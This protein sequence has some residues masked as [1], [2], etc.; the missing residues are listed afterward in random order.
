MP[1]KLSQPFQAHFYNKNRNIRII[2]CFHLKFSRV[3]DIQRWRFYI[4][5][6]RAFTIVDDLIWPFVQNTGFNTSSGTESIFFFDFLQ[7]LLVLYFHLS[8]VEWIFRY[9]WFSFVLRCSLKRYLSFDERKMKN[10]VCVWK[11]TLLFL[12]IVSQ[13]M[14]VC[15]QQHVSLKISR[16]FVL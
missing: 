6:M 11:Y 9:H 4:V 12:L 16:H 13:N 14:V 2:Y 7:V 8:F 10:N 15:K 5:T 3:L 1:W